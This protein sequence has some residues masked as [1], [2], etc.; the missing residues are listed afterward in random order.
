ML[1]DQ[2]INETGTVRT[3]RLGKELK[4]KK[5]SISTEVRG[6]IKCHYEQNA[7]GVICRNDNGPIIMISNVHADLPLT[8]VKCWDSSRNHIK[9]DR[10]HCN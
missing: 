6:T 8:T 2:G 1:K 3:D 10:P 4:L 7:I 5:N 9:I